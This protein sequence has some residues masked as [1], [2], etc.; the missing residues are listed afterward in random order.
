MT[1]YTFVLDANGKQLAGKKEMK[2]TIKVRI[3]PEQ[4]ENLKILKTKPQKA[5]VDH[6]EYYQGT[7]ECIEVMQAYF[8]SE[9]VKAFCRCSSLKYRFRAGNKEGESKEKDL[10]KADWYDN[11]LVEMIKK[12]KWGE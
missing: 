2:K 8:G 7:H 12:E 6:P 4:K 5:A 3:T 9:A 11:Y 1:N 10:A